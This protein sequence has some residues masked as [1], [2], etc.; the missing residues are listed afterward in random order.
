MS[1]F[2]EKRRIAVTGNVRFIYK[3]TFTLILAVLL[4]LVIS[5]GQE[6][7]K[8][9]TM[10]SLFRRVIE[11][12]GDEYITVRDEIVR[13]GEPA[14]TFLEKQVS[15]PDWKTGIIAEVILGRIREPQKYRHY[16]EMM[17]V[18]IIKSLTAG[19]GTV[20]GPRPLRNIL[21][22]A[23][24][25][26]ESRDPNWY[27]GTAVFNE[28]KGKEQIWNQQTEAVP[29]FIEFC[30][31]D[32]LR[33]ELF[34]TKIIPPDELK[35]SYSCE[36]ISRLLGVTKL[37]AE[38]WCGSQGYLPYDNNGKIAAETL[39]EFMNILPQNFNVPK[40]EIAMVVGRAHSAVWLGGFERKPVNEVLIEIVKSDTSDEVRACA[41]GQIR[42]KEGVDTLLECL[43]GECEPVR[44]TAAVSLAIIGDNRAI[45][46]LKESLGS[47]Y[48][49]DEN[50]QRI[51]AL[52]IGKLDIGVLLEIMNEESVAGVTAA[53]LQIEKN[54][55]TSVYVRI[56]KQGNGITKPHAAR[57]LG[58]IRDSNSVEALIE[59]L[60]DTDRYLRECIIDALANIGGIRAMEALKKVSVEDEYWYIRQQASNALYKPQIYEEWNKEETES[61]EKI[62]DWKDKDTDALIAGLSDPRPGIRM[63]SASWLRNKNDAARAVPKLI[64]LLK[65]TDRKVREAVAYTLRQIKEPNSVGP[66]VEAVIEEDAGVLS[67]RVAIANAL[68]NINSSLALKILDEKLNDPVYSDK[69]PRI[70]MSLRDMRDANAVSIL[71]PLALSENINQRRQSLRTQALRA[72]VELSIDETQK[73]Y[74]SVDPNLKREILMQIQQAGNVKGPVVIQIIMEALR[75]NNSN[76]KSMGAFALRSKISELKETER[77][78][79]LNDNDAYVRR[80]FIEAIPDFEQNKYINYIVRGLKDDNADV[81]LGTVKILGRRREM[82]FV[83]V[84][85]ESLEK[86]STKTIQTEILNVL[87]YTTGNELTTEQWVTWWNE[88]SKISE[89]MSP[90]QFKIVE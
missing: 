16:E 65:D 10:Q 88:N 1:E 17:A 63:N 32:C 68:R 86:E 34:F 64:E 26:S 30:L 60:N 2:F 74:H 53:I 8:D 19:E 45:I 39:R 6:Q 81:R 70:I 55:P 50:S 36:E 80:A 78:S 62:I 3:R 27:G 7:S 38:Q 56:L 49:N 21:W 73:L 47:E 67:A 41:A 20:S 18:V 31:K 66:L 54:I 43:K 72:I 48:K 23:Q 58:Q 9:Q 87:R 13:I 76:I 75:D 82:R 33:K 5:S 29:F 79:G 59:A 46:P 22:M 51:I 90:D 11:M 25:A 14:A 28:Q 37:T 84:L 12:R 24:H 89:T 15:N 69:Q 42:G 71:K 83:G 35:E 44:V 40:V 57:V 77:I 4:P 61:K 52:S 85:V